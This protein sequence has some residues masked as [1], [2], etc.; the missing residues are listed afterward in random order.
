MKKTFKFFFEPSEE[1][2][3][4]YYESLGKTLLFK[5]DQVNP[6]MLSRVFESAMFLSSFERGQVIEEMEEFVKKEFEKLQDRF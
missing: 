4:V 1:Q 5:V 3:Y 6:T 2:Y